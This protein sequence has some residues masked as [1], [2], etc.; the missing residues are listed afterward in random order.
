VNASK[1]AK[2]INPTIMIQGHTLNGSLLPLVSLGGKPSVS[3]VS[4]EKNIPAATLNPTS[5]PQSEQIKNPNTKPPAGTHNAMLNTDRS[6]R[7]LLFMLRSNDY[8]LG[9][10]VADCFSLLRQLTVHPRDVTS[11]CANWFSNIHDLY[12]RSIDRINV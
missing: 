4:K 7:C 11:H 1:I 2:I 9:I 5:Q 12:A 3:G 6:N 8:M 10:I